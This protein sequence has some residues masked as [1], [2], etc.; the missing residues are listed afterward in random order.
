MGRLS[1]LVAGIGQATI[2]AHWDRTSLTAL[3]ADETPSGKKPSA[4]GCT[5]CRRLWSPR[6]PLPRLRA[7]AE[8]TVRR[9]PVPG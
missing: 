9:G 6:F 8:D 7:G 2:A 4:Q 1:S 5:A 3:T